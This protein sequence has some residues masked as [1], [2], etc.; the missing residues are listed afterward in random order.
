LK[1][2]RKVWF[3]KIKPFVSL[4]KPILPNVA[5]IQNNAFDIKVYHDCGDG[6]MLIRLYDRYGNKRIEQE[7]TKGTNT[8]EMAQGGFADGVYVYV[9]EITAENGEVVRATGDLLV[10]KN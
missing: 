9:L 10:L 4:C 8:I 6:K 2:H 5:K 1:L 7:V 3:V